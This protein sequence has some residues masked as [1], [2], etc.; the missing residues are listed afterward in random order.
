MMHFAEFTQIKK[1]EYPYKGAKSEPLPLYLIYCVHLYGSTNQ[2]KFLDS[3]FV[4]IILLEDSPQ[5]D[6]M[7]ITD[8]FSNI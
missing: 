8:M 6:D 2:R 3:P 7:L 4:T 1:I 5:M